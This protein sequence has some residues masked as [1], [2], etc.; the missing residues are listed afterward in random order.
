[1]DGPA[2]E[3]EQIYYYANEPNRCPSRLLD[4]NGKV[5]WAAL[6]EANSR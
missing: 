4:E 6:Q 3:N 5:V 1:M 2:G